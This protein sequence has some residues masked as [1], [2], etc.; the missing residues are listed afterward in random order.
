[1]DNIDLQIAPAIGDL[2]HFDLHANTIVTTKLER[3][4]V[5]VRWLYYEVTLSQFKYYRST[6]DFCFRTKSIHLKSLYRRELYTMCTMSLA[7]VTASGLIEIKDVP[8]TV[9]SCVLFAKCK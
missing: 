9:K 1:M 8:S 2:L 3:S 6:W 5:D 7:H 4:L